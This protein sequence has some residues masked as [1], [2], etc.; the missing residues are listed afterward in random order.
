MNQIHTELSD[1]KYPSTMKNWVKRN[2]AF[3]LF[4]RLF[5]FFRAMPVQSEQHCVDFS[6]QI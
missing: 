3:A 1:I 6:S 5:F 4:S 2:L